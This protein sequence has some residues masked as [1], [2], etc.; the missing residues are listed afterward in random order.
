MRAGRGPDLERGRTD[1]L[2]VEEDL[3]ASWIRRHR[4]QRRSLGL[5]PL[6]RDAHRQSLA[7]VERHLLRHRLVSFARD[8][9]VV[10]ARLDFRGEGRLAKLLAVDANRRRQ[11]GIHV[12]A[13]GAGALQREGEVG[14]AV[15]MDLDRPLLLDES[16][17]RD[18]HAVRAR[19]RFRGPG[20]DADLCP[21]HR[22][23]GA[24]WRG[25]DCQARPAPVAGGQIEPDGQIAVLRHVEVGAHLAAAF[26]AQHEL[27]VSLRQ[28]HDQR[29]AA[30]LLAIYENDRADR[31][32]L[33][34]KSGRLRQRGQ[35]ERQAR[36]TPL[37]RKH[38]ALLAQAAL[39]LDRHDV[40]A[41]LERALIRRAP[42]KRAVDQDVRLGRVA[43]HRQHRGP[44]RLPRQVH[45]EVHPAALDLDLLFRAPPVGTSD[46]QRVAP[47]HQPDAQRRGAGVL[48]V[49]A[50]GRARLLGANGHRDGRGRGIERG[51]GERLPRRS[52]ARGL[53]LVVLRL[54]EVF[55]RP[56]R[57]DAR[58]KPRFEAPL[59]AAIA[60]RERL[61][62]VVSRLA[63]EHQRRKQP[64][65]VLY[66]RLDHDRL[67]THRPLHGRVR[68]L[69]VATAPGWRVRFYADSLFPHCEQAA[70]TPI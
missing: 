25:R 69:L 39:Q 6:Q 64:R 43:V 8:L 26:L 45:G 62:A 10:L 9:Q 67:A 3:C 60:H 27:V 29:R 31:V 61:V 47:R 42:E 57:E 12:Q 24:G 50:N 30:P 19:F 40:L 11:L 41:G 68:D 70:L 7:G 44:A 17:A 4:D 55:E 1:Q 35:R 65:R 15:K 56:L 54:D 20:R 21:I 2:L 34:R 53:A 59:G 66:L 48:V 32:R 22:H 5:C 63:R 28:R 51:A 23:G 14:V 37:A 49:D 13:R 33:D 38:G 18:R 46:G 52:H 36:V 58:R 16:G